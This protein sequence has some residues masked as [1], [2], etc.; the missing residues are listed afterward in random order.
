MPISWSANLGKTI[1]KALV[2][3]QKNCQASPDRGTLDLIWIADCRLAM[4]F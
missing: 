1:H 3:D 2:L 4:D